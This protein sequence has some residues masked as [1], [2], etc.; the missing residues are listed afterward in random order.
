MNAAAAGV[1]WF[2]FE[3]AC[4]ELFGA[5]THTHVIITSNLDINFLINK[6]NTLE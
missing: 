5:H 4:V 6:K 2:D 1:D 3:R